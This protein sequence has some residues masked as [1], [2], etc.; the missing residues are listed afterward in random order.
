MLT[1][2][3][4][5]HGAGDDN[6]RQ[7]E[8]QGCDDREFAGDLASAT[9]R[10]VGAPDVGPGGDDS[11]D[12]HARHQ[13]RANQD[14]YSQISKRGCGAHHNAHNCAELHQHGRF[15]T[16]AGV[17]RAGPQEA[18]DGGQGRRRCQQG[19]GEI[20][21]VEGYVESAAIGLLAGRFAA[22]DLQGVEI[23]SPPPTTALGALLHHITRGADEKTFQPMNINFGLFPPL[24]GGTA[25]GRE[26]KQAMAHRALA[27]LDS[28]LGK[29]RAAAE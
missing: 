7:S 29:T 1:S 11:G 4:R 15:D 10:V 9:A 26:R 18:G 19:D 28:W 2:P 14:P 23:L 6:R 3:G 21:G 25:R 27:D 16:I 5:I 8:D 13:R 20:S 22:G 24:E 12:E 17:Y